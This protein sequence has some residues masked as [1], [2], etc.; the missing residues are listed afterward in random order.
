MVS[1]M[2]RQ[3]QCARCRSF[4]PLFWMKVNRTTEIDGRFEEEKWCLNC[5]RNADLNINL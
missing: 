5:I 4:N 2:E 1:D 3:Q